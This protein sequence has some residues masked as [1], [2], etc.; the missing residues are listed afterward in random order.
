M[1]GFVARD[2]AKAT[3]T[4]FAHDL[5][6][7][8]EILRANELS[9][10]GAREIENASYNLWHSEGQQSFIKFDVPNIDIRIVSPS[11]IMPASVIIDDRLLADISFKEIHKKNPVI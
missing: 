5:R 2:R 1:I 11:H 4:N 8:A 3:V 6:V 9:I 7:L 10:S